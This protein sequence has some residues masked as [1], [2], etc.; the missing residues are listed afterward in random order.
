MERGFS[1]PRS[2]T[3]KLFKP[4]FMHPAILKNGRKPGR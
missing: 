3:N 2:I 4:F 1:Y